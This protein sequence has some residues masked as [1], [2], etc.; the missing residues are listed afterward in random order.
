MLTE[1]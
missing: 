1:F